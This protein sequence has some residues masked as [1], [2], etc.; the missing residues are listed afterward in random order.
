MQSGEGP[1]K[2]S[3]VYGGAALLFVVGFGAMQIAAPRGAAQPVVATA[4]QASEDP[5]AAARALLKTIRFEERLREA[6]PAL[7]AAVEAS[8]VAAHP[9]CAAEMG[10]IA[11]ALDAATTQLVARLAESGAAI[12][13]QRFSAG[14]L[15]SIAAYLGGAQG[16]GET[17]AFRQTPTG[18]KFLAQREQIARDLRGANAGSLRQ[19]LDEAMRAELRKRGRA[20]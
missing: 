6:M 8:V 16:D 7:R 18:A 20:V 3:V 1:V 17:A 10:A 15:R 5:Q 9:D 19:A 2:N 4:A 14:E 11:P 12:Y 13:A